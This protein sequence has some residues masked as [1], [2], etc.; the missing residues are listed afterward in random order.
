MS[1][2][3]PVTWLPAH[4]SSAA[5]PIRGRNELARTRS[6][7]P[8][9]ACEFEVFCGLDVARETHHAVALDPGGRA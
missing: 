8:I 4:S 1:G 2:C 6:V 5:L 3:L 9:V 7:V